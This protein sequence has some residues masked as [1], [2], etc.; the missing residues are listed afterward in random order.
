A[1][2]VAAARS[3]ALK[4]NQ[5]VWLLLDKAARSSRIQ[6]VGG[7]GAVVDIGGTEFLPATVAFTGIAGATAEV[8]FDAMGRLVNAPRTVNIQSMRLGT[9]RTVTVVI[10]GRITI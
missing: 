7:G 2:K 5:Q 6:T 3:E 1:S 9:Q 10:T 8:R 4:R